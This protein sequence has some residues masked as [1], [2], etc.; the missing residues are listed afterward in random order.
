[1]TMRTINSW[2]SETR[3]GFPTPHAAESIDTFLEVLFRGAGIRFT[4][5]A[6]RSKK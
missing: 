4:I 1:M 5:H 6:G 2:P 3:R